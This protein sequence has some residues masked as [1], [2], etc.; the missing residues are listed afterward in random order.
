VEATCSLLK[1]KKIKRAGLFGTKS[2]MTAGFYQKEADKY[3]IEVIVPD[4]E[5]QHY[6]HEKYMN[7]LVFNT[8]KKETKS[9]LLEIAGQ[10]KINSNIEG[11]ILGGTE[12]PLII[13]QD[14]LQEMEILDTTVNHV[15]RIVSYAVEE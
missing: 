8:I 1:D 11:L 7:E 13:N 10:L 4:A 3:G 15:N 12:L 14:D 6:I 5:S 9:R 2:T